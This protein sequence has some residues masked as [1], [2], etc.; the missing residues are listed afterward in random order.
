MI[1]VKN[2]AFS[3]SPESP[4]VFSE[5][6]LTLKEGEF[7]S[8]M[9]SNG[10]GKTTLARC[11]NGLNLPSRGEVWV[12]GL[13]SSDPAENMKI[14]A[15]VGMVFQ[16]PDNQ[17]VSTTVER[18]VAFGLENLGIPHAEM[19]P[20]VEEKLRQF[21]LEKYRYRAPHTLSG[22]EKQLLALASVL[23][24]KPRY[25]IFDEPTSLLDPLWRER[26]LETVA[27]LHKSGQITPILITQFPEETL[28]SDRLIVLNEGKIFLDDSPGKIFEK[29]EPLREAGVG[30]PLKFQIRSLLPDGYRWE[31]EA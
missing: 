23:A 31:G 13:N 10:S 26:I 27:E 4:F 7:V 21:D 15:R 11:L 5:L 16:N 6:N 24:M 22:G 14:R 17:I 8:F 12:D 2:L 1:V 3:Y 18:E 19:Q 29:P 25:V 28:Q 9:G 20:I 30:I